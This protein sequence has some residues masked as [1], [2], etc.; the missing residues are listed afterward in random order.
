MNIIKKYRFYFSLSLIILFASVMVS[1]CKEDDRHYLPLN[2]GNRWEYKLNNGSSEVYHIS[3]KVEVD[4]VPLYKCEVLKDGN[5]IE[6]VY[7]EGEVNGEISLSF[8]PPYDEQIKLIPPFYISEDLQWNGG[9]GDLYKVCI[10]SF[11]EKVEY[12]GKDLRALVLRLEKNEQVFSRLT[13]I[14][15]IGIV[16][17]E[18][19]DDDGKTEVGKLVN[20][21]VKIDREKIAQ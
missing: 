9:D 6:E 12:N 2:V 3:E 11:D 8:Y 13:L 7:F 16:G 10:E 15:G 19:Y 21:R 4:E 14:K 18:Y 20:C 5:L 1:G 17:F